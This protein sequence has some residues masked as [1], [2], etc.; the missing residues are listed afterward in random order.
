MCK[1]KVQPFHPILAIPYILFL[2][3]VM[4][5]T[6]EHSLFVFFLVSTRGG[7]RGGSGGSDEPPKIISTMGLVDFFVISPCAASEV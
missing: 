7:Y 4:L 6:P 5:V 1:S 2:N 3:S